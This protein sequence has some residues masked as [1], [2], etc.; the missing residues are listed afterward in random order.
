MNLIAVNMP[1]QLKSLG[2]YAFA[3]C[4]ALEEITFPDGLSYISPSAYERCRS[5]EK[6]LFPILLTCLQREHSVIAA[7][8]VRLS[9]EKVSATL[10][11]EIVNS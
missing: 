2:E 6:S 8:L 5:L 9:L 10:H 1:A 11:T 3:G 4:S 7:T